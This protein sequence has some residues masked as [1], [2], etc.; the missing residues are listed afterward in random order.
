MKTRK[1]AV[2]QPYFLTWLGTYYF[3]YHSDVFIALDDGLFLKTDVY[4]LWHKNTFNVNI[5][6][7]S[8][9]I[10]IVFGQKEFE[11]VNEIRIKHEIYFTKKHLTT[12]K[13]M[14]ATKTHVQEVFDEV[15][16]PVYMKK[17]EFLVDF[18]MDM[19]MHVCRY[20][21]IET[22]HIKRSSELDYEH[23]CNRI[24]KYKNFVKQEGC[25][26][27]MVDEGKD[28]LLTEDED[29]G[30]MMELDPVFAKLHGEQDFLWHV[31]VKRILPKHFNILDILCE[32][33]KATIDFLK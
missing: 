13:Q 1:L 8:L 3:I 18:N 33:G 28:K 10:P 30:A 29:V 27:L 11:Q 12:I 20:L 15:V 14:M 31:P 19:I 21:G 5:T 9:T 6:E 7:R 25:D 17:H 26:V 16:L 24:E 22:D 23:P 32:Y 4:K 2:Q